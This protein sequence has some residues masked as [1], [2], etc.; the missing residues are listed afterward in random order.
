MKYE[1][2]ASEAKRKRYINNEMENLVCKKV[3]WI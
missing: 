3:S 2:R 1:K